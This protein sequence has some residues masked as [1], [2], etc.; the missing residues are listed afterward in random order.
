M[1]KSLKGIIS[2]HTIRIFYH[3]YFKSCMKYGIIFWLA[4]SYSKKVVGLQK[5]VIYLI[6]GI[7]G[8]ASSRN[9]FM[10]HKILTMV[11]IYIIEVLCVIKSI[12]C[13]L[14]IPYFLAYKTHH[15]FLVR[16]FRK[17][18]MMNVF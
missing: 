5:M 18:M 7:K 8:C 13:I 10:A 11:S 14:N 3:A 16:N 9:S 4:D 15:D 2:H 17:K 1:I 12:I 6:F